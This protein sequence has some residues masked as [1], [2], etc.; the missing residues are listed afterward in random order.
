M[1]V[2]CK[3]TIEHNVGNF[4]SWLKSKVEAEI[5]DMKNKKEEKK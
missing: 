4:D 2:D 5:Y 1:G 3:K